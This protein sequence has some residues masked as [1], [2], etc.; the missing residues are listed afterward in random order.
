VLANPVILD[1][2]PY[3]GQFNAYLEPLK[4]YYGGKQLMHYGAP[5]ED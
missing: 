1:Q 4:V 5:Q 3:K 2:Q